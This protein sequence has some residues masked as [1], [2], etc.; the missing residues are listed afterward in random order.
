MLEY[1]GMGAQCKQRSR[2]GVNGVHLEDERSCRFVVFV[3]VGAQA[4]GGL[5]GGR[6]C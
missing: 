2:S 6:L 4:A 1:V 5:E 3:A